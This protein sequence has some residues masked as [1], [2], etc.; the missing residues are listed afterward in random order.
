MAIPILLWILGGLAAAAA[1]AGDSNA[2]NAPDPVFTSKKRRIGIKSVSKVGTP[3]TMTRDERTGP[4]PAAA[5]AAWNSPKKG[6]RRSRS[7]Y[8]PDNDIHARGAWLR[9]ATYSDNW[10]KKL[11]KQRIYADPPGVFYVKS[12]SKVRNLCWMIMC[13]D[14]LYPGYG[15]AKRRNVRWDA[16]S[17][18]LSPKADWGTI[19]GTVKGAVE[20]I[21]S[22]VKG[23]GVV[24]AAVL[25]LGTSALAGAGDQVETVEEAIRNS[26]EVIGD[27]GKSVS[28][29]KRAA[30][31]VYEIIAAIYIQDVM[32]A[33]PHAVK[34]GALDIGKHYKADP[35]TWEDL[36]APG[37]SR[38]LL[39]MPH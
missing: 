4:L 2:T 18:W 22:L 13:P 7:A 6:K 12:T 11:E 37:K 19:T 5:L 23:A 26:L 10:D 16:M 21:P 31:A 17:K 8:G 30:R 33:N 15:K 28:K 3:V 9:Y 24:V 36:R 39:Y 34:N 35:K 38:P 14:D 20:A 32:R 25:S 27:T 29:R 1:A